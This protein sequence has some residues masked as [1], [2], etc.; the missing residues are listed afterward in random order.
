MPIHA[1]WDVSE[2]TTHIC[3][4]DTD[5]IIL[6]RDFVASDPDLLAKWFGK[7][8]DELLGE[9]S[10]PLLALRKFRVEY[11]LRR[12]DPIDFPKVSVT[13]TAKYACTSGDTQRRDRRQSSASECPA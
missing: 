7:P 4:V 11:C 5:G 3:V 8:C 10:D 13:S 1:G 12:V 9:S 6:K 2:K